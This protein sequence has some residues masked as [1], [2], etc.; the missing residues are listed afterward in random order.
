MY[1]LAYLYDNTHMR[2]TC[3][4]IVYSA[5]SVV[6]LEEVSMLLYDFNL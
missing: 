3:S 5:I 2:Q 6:V 4:S 1:I